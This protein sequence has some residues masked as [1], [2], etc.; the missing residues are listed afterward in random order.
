MNLRMMKIPVLA[1]IVCMTL[2][3]T[4]FGAEIEGVSFSDAHTVDDT[5]FTLVG[6][7]LLRYMVFIKAYVAVFYLEEG[8]A[9]EDVLSDIPKR[10]EIEYF[11]A[12]KTEDFA[13]SMN[14]LIPENIGFEKTNRLRPRIDRMNMLFENVRPGDRYSL[15]YIP[16]KGTELAL[17]GQPKGTVEG[18]DFAAAMFSIWLGP[19]PIKRSLKKA[20]LDQR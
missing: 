17:N 8:V 15:T 10:L 5:R 6:T 16:G 14:K 18:A 3:G 19:R 1:L 13:V 2:T 12:I 11:H 9:A 20:L 7:G 4:S